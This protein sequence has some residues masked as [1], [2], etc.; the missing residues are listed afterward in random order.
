MTT[1]KTNW[2][3]TEWHKCTIASVLCL[4]RRMNLGESFRWKKVFHGLR[5]PNGSTVKQFTLKISIFHSKSDKS[6]P[7]KSPHNNVM[8]WK[9]KSQRKCYLLFFWSKCTKCH[10]LCVCLLHAY[11]HSIAIIK[12]IWNRRTEGTTNTTKQIWRF[13]FVCIDLLWTNQP[14]NKPTNQCK[15]IWIPVFG[16]LVWKIHI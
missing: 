5:N 6:H 1:M 16:F 7:K 2:A 9:P 15:T 13:G 3:L 14:A 8:A 4:P 11:S 10:L 12:N